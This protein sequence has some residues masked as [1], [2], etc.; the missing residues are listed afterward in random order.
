MGIPDGLYLGSPIT[1]SFALGLIGGAITLGD[2]AFDIA[3]TTLT[4]F[5]NIFDLGFGSIT[6]TRIDESTAFNSTT[7]SVY[8]VDEDAGVVTLQYSVVPEPSSVALMIGGLVVLARRRRR[9]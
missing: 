3:Y 1:G 2:D 7:D 9:E 4:G 6:A 5:D 8:W